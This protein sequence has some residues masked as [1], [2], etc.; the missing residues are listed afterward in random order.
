MPICAQKLKLELSQY[1]GTQQYLFNRLYPKMKYT[2]GVKAMA[3]MA[4]AYWLLDLIGTEFFPRQESGE[5]DYFV[6]FKLHVAN[7]TMAI[8]ITDGDCNEYLQHD[9]TYTDFP[10]GDWEL[11][12]IEGILI[13]PSEY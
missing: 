7:N 5:W 13:L 1:T 3:I 10:E 11:W 9:I 6:T 2:D 12:L 8:T 4:E